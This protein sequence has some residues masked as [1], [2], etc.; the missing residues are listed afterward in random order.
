MEQHSLD[1]MA[2]RLRTVFE[3]HGVL[4]AIV[5]GSF[6]R[7]EVSRHSDLDLIVLQDTEKRFLSRYDGLLHE[8]FQAV[9]GRDID[10]LVYTPDELAQMMHRPLIASALKEGKTIY[11]SE[12]KS[13]SG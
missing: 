7:G 6:A 3:K 5:F 10:L 12:Q 8:I 9:P 13:A 11:E 2:S 1:E 4:R